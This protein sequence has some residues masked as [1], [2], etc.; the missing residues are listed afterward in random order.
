M[1]DYTEMHSLVLISSISPSATYFF[2]TLVI[3]YKWWEN[4]LGKS[5]SYLKFAIWW[6]GGVRVT[7]FDFEFPWWEREQQNYW[8]RYL[9]VRKRGK[10]LCNENIL[11]LIVSYFNRSLGQL[12]SGVGLKRRLQFQAPTIQLPRS[13]RI[14]KHPCSRPCSSHLITSNLIPQFCQ[15]G[16][17]IVSYTKHGESQDWINCWHYAYWS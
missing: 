7:H 1:I 6:L 2:N 9:N 3:L 11:N 15:F 8:V 16:V 4:H 12:P 5:F 14:G 17:F 10:K 13:S